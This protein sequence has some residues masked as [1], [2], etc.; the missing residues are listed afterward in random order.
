[1]LLQGW[2]RRLVPEVALEQQRLD[3][4]SKASQGAARA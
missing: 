1:M 4:G 3:E 2:V